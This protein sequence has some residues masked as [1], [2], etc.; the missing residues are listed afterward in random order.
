MKIIESGKASPLINKMILENNLSD[1]LTD[2]LL[3]RME[4]CLY[5]SGEN[6]I[7]E[8]EAMQHYFFFITGRLKIFQTYENGKSL[9][10]QFYTTMDSLGEVELIEECEAFCSVSCIMDSLLL[11]LPM[12]EMKAIL[13]QN[14]PF[15]TYVSKSLSR[16]LTSANHNQAFNLLYPVKYRLASYLLWHCPDKKEVRYAESFQ[17]ISE[18]IGTSYRQFNRALNLLIE[19]GYVEKKGKKIRI[20]S[21]DALVKLSGH[22]YIGA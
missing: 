2:S 19:E 13:Y 5:E 4:L 11:R 17:E 21:Y 1:I 14:L 9:L 18:F 8:G 15:L 6:I 16:K 3:E 20:L 22:I 12:Y 7:R 10:I